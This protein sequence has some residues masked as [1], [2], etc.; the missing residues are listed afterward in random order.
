MRHRFNPA[1]HALNARFGWVASALT[2]LVG[3]AVTV[4]A[5]PI[6]QFRPAA[7][8]IDRWNYPFDSAPGF[9]ESGATFSALGQEDAFPGFSF[10][11]RDAQVVL[12]W[13]TNG[14]IP[15]GL[16]VCR[17]EIIGASVTIAV[18]GEIAFRY[19]PTYDLRASYMSGAP[20]PDLG[21]PIELY[22]TG[23]RNNWNTG[24][25]TQAGCPVPGSGFEGFP[26]W[27]EGN[28]DLPGPPFGPCVCKDQRNVFATD[29][30]GGVSRDISNNIRDG[31][32]PKPFAVGQI[33]GVT[34]GN[35]VTDARDVTFALNVGDA[36]VQ[37]Y[38]RAGVDAGR[39]LLTISSLQPAASVGGPGSGEY[40]RWFMK[41][42][43]LGNLGGVTRW[44]RLALDVRVV[45]LVG[46]LNNDGAV[47]TADLTRFL[48]QFGSTG[49]FLSA[50]LNCDGAVN[51]ADLT[52]FLG[53]FG[54]SE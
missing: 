31:F 8:T 52:R 16:G 53:Q 44:A 42:N 36:D 39:V 49:A 1:N 45:T 20:D 21:R 47:N 25:P 46:D 28:V 4:D 41:E 34:A 19:D 13:D 50:D 43:P 48:G 5:A 7:P 22:G 54:R 35:Y 38:L 3:S 14:V 15:T 51:T 9:S 11:Q 18:T 23:F 24:A 17:Y 29:F 2:V 30:L 26:C 33:A 40:A 6:I 37:R 27:Y 32:D 10:D 12:G